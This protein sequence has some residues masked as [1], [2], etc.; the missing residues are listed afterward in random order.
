MA[1]ESANNTILKIEGITNQISESVD[2]NISTLKSDIKTDGLL[3]SDQVQSDISVY[4]IYLTRGVNTVLTRCTYHLTNA[5]YHASPALLTFLI[6]AI[7]IIKKIWDVVKIVI[8]VISVIKTFHIDDLLYKWWPWYSDQ[9]D[10]I[11]EFVQDMS[12]TLG[13]GVDGLMH[14]INVCQGG[15]SVYGGLTNKGEDWHKLQGLLSME[16]TLK[17]L[18][19]YTSIGYSEPGD[20][21]GYIFE[22]QSIKS[23]SWLRDWSGENL[24]RIQNVVDITE[25]TL[26]TVGTMGRELR[27]ISENMPD[28]ISQYIPTKIWDSLDNF[29]ILIYQDI[30]PSVTAVSDSLDEID[31]VLKAYQ[32]KLS[33]LAGKLSKPGDLLSNVD[34]LS[35]S[36]RL[37]QE[38]LIDDIASREFQRLTD[39]ERA[40]L[41][42]DL[43]EFDLI[44][45]AQSA[46]T[47]EPKFMSLESPKRAA[48][49]GIKLEPSE[50]WFLKADY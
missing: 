5:I 36:E 13:W 45:A 10:K 12:E 37:Q 42:S 49:T 2:R 7:I 14:L 9:V 23:M 33:A 43:D 39:A 20:L 34:E 41:E 32:D 21:L 44:D 4:D 22:N 8:T 25:T 3:I 28:M 11:R 48:L 15:I 18:Q 24:E 19:T 16:D 40:A 47:P 29:E 17:N 30:L 35:D 50:T 31:S 1:F 27:A 46:E 26:D 6:S 38:S